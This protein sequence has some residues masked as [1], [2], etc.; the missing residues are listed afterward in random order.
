MDKTLFVLSTEHR[1][2]AISDALKFIGE[3]FVNYVQ[4]ARQRDIVVPDNIYN[5]LI[6]T[7]EERPLTS[8]EIKTLITYIKQRQNRILID[9]NVPLTTGKLLASLIL[10][11]I[12]K[13]ATLIFFLMEW[14]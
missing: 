5:L 2:M 14:H 6:D 4:K 8:S 13:T 3:D 7:I 9:F 10:F 11:K 12:C 1:N